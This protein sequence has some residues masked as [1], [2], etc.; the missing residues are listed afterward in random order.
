MLKCRLDY[1][2]WHPV[3]LI[4]ITP[5]CRNRCVLPQFKLPYL[6]DLPDRSIRHSLQTYMRLDDILDLTGELHTF[7]FVAK[8]S[9]VRS[10]PI[11]DF[12]VQ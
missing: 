2:Y 5:D 4:I 1:T 7:V 8:A 9:T 12:R 10:H 11:S 3:V 6:S